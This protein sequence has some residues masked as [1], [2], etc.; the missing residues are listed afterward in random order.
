MGVSETDS[1]QIEKASLILPVG[2]SSKFTIDSHSLRTAYW[3]SWP[4]MKQHSVRSSFFRTREAAGKRA[5][6]LTVR[7]PDALG[8]G[9]AIVDHRPHAEPAEGVVV[10]APGDGVQVVGVEAAVARDAAPAGVVALSA[11]IS[12]AS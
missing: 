8:H 2:S 1:R 4:E 10:R 9:A 12:L 3:T 7:V 6:E 11:P 5:A